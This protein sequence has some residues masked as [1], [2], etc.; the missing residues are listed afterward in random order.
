MA[1]IVTLNS[2]I[3]KVQVNGLVLDWVGQQ[4]TI[5]LGTTTGTVFSEEYFGQEAADLMVML[6]KANLS[7]K[8][9]HKRILEK[10]VAD[11]RITGAISGVPD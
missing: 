11:G 7:V 2:P 3:T 6:N 8:S 10:L 1:E 4:I 5:I 9:L